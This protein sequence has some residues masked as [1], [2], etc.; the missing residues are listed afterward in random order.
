M[1]ESAEGHILPTSWTEFRSIEF[2]LAQRW[3]DHRPPRQPTFCDHR[4]PTLHQSRRTH[5]PTRLC[6]ISTSARS[7]TITPSPHHPQGG[8]PVAQRPLRLAQDA[9]DMAR[10][11]LLRTGHLAGRAHPCG[12][13]SG[14]GEN[15]RIVMPMA[16]RE[17]TF[18]PSGMLHDSQ[19]A[20]VPTVL[21]NQTL[22]DARLIVHALAKPPRWCEH[23]IVF[24]EAESC[25]DYIEKTLGQQSLSAASAK[26]CEEVSK[27]R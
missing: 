11:L 20:R 9:E 19:S 27:P 6:M 24:R 3:A 17:A 15:G 14:S 23:L 5:V 10:L 7:V 22:A 18:E 8:V 25:P 12:L 1:G 16:P 21:R 26:R 13:Q 2:L 4:H